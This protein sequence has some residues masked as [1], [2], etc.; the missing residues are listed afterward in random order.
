MELKQK[1]KKLQEALAKMQAKISNN[2]D[3]LNA[4]SHMWAVKQASDDNLKLACKVSE[5]VDSQN[6]YKVHFPAA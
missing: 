3:V 1:Q 5:R 4:Q 2:Q 6:Y